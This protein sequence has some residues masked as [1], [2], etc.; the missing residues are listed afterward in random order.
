MNR[1]VGAMEA[2]YE[3]LPVVLRKLP[4]VDAIR[5]RAVC[6]GWR[7][8]ID[9]DKFKFEFGKPCSY[10]PLVFK[11]T[12]GEHTWSGYDAT[13][14]KWESLPSLSNAPRNISLLPILGSGNGSVGFGVLGSYSAYI[15]ANPYLQKWKTLP[16][17]PDC[18]GHAAM[19]MSS[20][21]LGGFQ[22]VAVR[23]DDTYIYESEHDRWREVGHPP[24]CV[25]EGQVIPR[26]KD[27]ACVAFCNNRLYT[28]SADGDMLIS[29]DMRTKQWANQRFPFDPDVCHF[30]ESE[31]KSMQLVEC[32]GT[33]FAVTEDEQIG[34]IAVWG[35]GTRLGQLSLTVTMPLTVQHFLKPNPPTPYR[36][37]SK[38]KKVISTGHGHQLFFWRHGSLT[39][40]SYDLFTHKWDMLPDIAMARAGE[41]DISELQV[42][43]DIGFFEPL[44]IVQ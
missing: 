21:E 34:R 15:I 17:S 20:D 39:I 25:K 33:L 1:E 43:V 32:S 24:R 31:K 8:C 10:C 18:W 28:T 23:N 30:S 26:I 29:F 19:F 5:A 35:I 22:V 9:A 7:D 42:K 27:K 4:L 37:R 36:R 38:P 6:R 3:V 13:T 2:F 12:D 11:L 44:N 41:E 40:I 16:S 14:L